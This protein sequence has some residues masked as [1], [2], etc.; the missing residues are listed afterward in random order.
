MDLWLTES[1]FV[2]KPFVRRCEE[3]YPKESRD[4]GSPRHWKRLAMTEDDGSPRLVSEA[5]A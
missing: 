3:R 4:S 2:M 1:C 5:P